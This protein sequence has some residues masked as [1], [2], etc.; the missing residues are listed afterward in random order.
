M[1]SYG[2]IGPQ[3]VNDVF[4]ED[5]KWW[6]QIIFQPMSSLH[7]RY[8][9]FYA[10]AEIILV[11]GSGKERRH[12]RITSSLIGW[13]RTQDNPCDGLTL[14]WICWPVPFPPAIPN[15]ANL[16][17]LHRSVYHPAIVYIFTFGKNV[18]NSHVSKTVCLMNIRNPITMQT[19][20]YN[21]T[22]RA[23]KWN[24]HSPYVSI[25]E[26]TNLGLKMSTKCRPLCPGPLRWKYNQFNDV[27]FIDCT[28]SCHFVSFPV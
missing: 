1:T 20:V 14:D 2:G 23:K 7:V 6:M 17:I 27:F 25:V 13:A 26:I 11:M 22:W 18:S 9:E 19:Y 8:V 5:S 12:Y 4:N 3:W 24:G 28:G 16:I 10:D 21:V 15:T